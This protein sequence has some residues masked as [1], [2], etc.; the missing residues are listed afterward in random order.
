MDIDEVRA[1]FVARG[2]GIGANDRLLYERVAGQLE[3]GETL[4][5]TTPAT[6]NNLVGTLVLTDRR[7]IHI[8]GHP[9]GMTVTQAA[10]HD[11]T[12]VKSGGLLVP[13][14]TIQHRGGTMRLVG[15]LKPVLSAMAAAL[16]PAESQPK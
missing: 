7:I 11:V 4:E 14:T 13:K 15:G 5:L 2:H 1:W 9:L 6:C 8:A 16:R 12:S 10:R 3:P